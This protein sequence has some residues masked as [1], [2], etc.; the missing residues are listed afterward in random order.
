MDSFF[1]YL[2]FFIPNKTQGSVGGFSIGTEPEVVEHQKLSAAGYTYS[3]SAPPFVCTAATVGLQKM[4]ENPN[5]CQQVRQN[6]TTL[7]NGLHNSTTTTTFEILS[8]AISPLCIVRLKKNV[9]ESIANEIEDGQNQRENMERACIQSIVH[10][11]ISEHGVFVV[12]SKYNLSALYTMTKKNG[13]K[14]ENENGNENGKNATTL[15]PADPINSIRLVV[16]TL[17][18]EAQIKKAAQC[19]LEVSEQVCRDMYGDD[20]VSAAMSEGEK[21]KVVKKNKKRTP[22]KKKSTSRGS[23]SKSTGRK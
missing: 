22:V 5:M 19:L 1:F 20:V 15:G 21:K 18:T 9:V 13:N 3:A 10:T 14:N 2:L 4:L 12:A 23:R 16:S 11:M 7:Y 6:A 17:H 8:D